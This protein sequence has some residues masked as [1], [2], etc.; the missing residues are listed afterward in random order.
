MRKKYRYPK[1]FELELFQSMM[2]RDMDCIM[3][4]QFQKLTK[5]LEFLRKTCKLD[6][7][8]VHYSWFDFLSSDGAEEDVLAYHFMF[9]FLYS[10][11]T[12]EYLLIERL[13]LVLMSKRFLIDW[14]GY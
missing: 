1:K 8:M 7:G 9:Y 5:L 4:D 2:E 10:G 12:P 3:S 6:G 13:I 14:I 11:V